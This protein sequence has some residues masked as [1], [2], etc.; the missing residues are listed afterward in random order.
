MTVEEEYGLDCSAPGIQLAFNPIISSVAL[1][2][3]GPEAKDIYEQLAAELEHD[4]AEVILHVK[5]QPRR[6]KLN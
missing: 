2:I 3:T 6:A 4:E 1:I 5:K